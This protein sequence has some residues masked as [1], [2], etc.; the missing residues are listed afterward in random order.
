MYL[1]SQIIKKGQRL[2]IYHIPT[3]ELREATNKDYSERLVWS[4]RTQ[5]AVKS[6]NYDFDCRYVVSFNRK[7]AIRK[8]AKFG[9]LVKKQEA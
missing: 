8:L 1:G 6:I 7:N 5:R 4:G 2:F 9:Y 3:L